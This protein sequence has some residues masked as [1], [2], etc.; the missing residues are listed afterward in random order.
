MKQGETVKH[1]QLGKQ[2]CVGNVYWGASLIMPKS[3]Y[4]RSPLRDAK[5]LPGGNE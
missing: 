1:I 5:R 4:T 2:G 3:R